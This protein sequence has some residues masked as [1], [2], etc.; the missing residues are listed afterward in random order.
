MELK[1][2]L[3]VAAIALAA[4]CQS[5]SVQV[6]PSPVTEGDDITGVVAGP[7]GPEAGVWVIAETFD[8]PTKYTKIVVTVERGR[9]AFPD[10]PRVRFNVW[11]RAYGLVDSAKVPA[12]PGQTRCASFHPSVSA[13][14]S[15]WTGWFES[16]PAAESH[17]PPR[18]PV[19]RR[20]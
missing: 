5:Q 19:T 20:L 18:G 15:A 13:P 1:Q 8:L 7:K 14:K 12:L 3:S 9:Y 10:L 17:R 6:K 2:A 11:V 4:G 16:C